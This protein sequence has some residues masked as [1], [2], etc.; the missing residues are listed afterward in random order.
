MH[1]DFNK[2]KSLQVLPLEVQFGT[3]IEKYKYFVIDVLKMSIEFICSYWYRNPNFI[4]LWL[5]YH[6]V[7]RRHVI[8]FSVDCEM[9]HK[10]VI[11]NVS[12]A[13]SDRCL[14]RIK[15]RISLWIPYLDRVSCRID[16]D[17]VWLVR[18]LH[19][20]SSTYYKMI[21][22]DDTDIMVIGGT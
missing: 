3:T 19:H 6:Y 8:R 16:V 12:L 7:V 5:C 20:Y 21:Q 11:E 17:H 15:L 18:R 10:S 14:C 1:K 9:R 13:P 22:V 4:I 2:P